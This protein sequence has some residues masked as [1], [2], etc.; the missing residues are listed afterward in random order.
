MSEHTKGKLKLDT[1]GGCLD[2]VTDDAKE[3]FIAK[4]EV[5]SVA[6]STETRE[7]NARRLVACWNALDGIST[8]DLESGNLA[9]AYLAKIFKDLKSKGLS[10]PIEAPD[11]S[12]K[13]TPGNAGP[14]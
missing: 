11:V 8:E 12:R 5:T 13:G 6:T 14:T 1:W 3:I 10:C 9:E 4:V 2:I 7:A